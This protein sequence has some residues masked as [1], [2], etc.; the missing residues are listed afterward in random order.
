MYK[1]FSQRKFHLFLITFFTGLFLGLNFSHIAR[2]NSSAQKYLEYFHQVYQLIVSEYVEEPDNKTIFF[3]AIKG[4]ISS[5]GDP[6][7]RVLDEE[8]SSQLQEMTTG[9]FV[10]IGIEIAVRDGEIVVVAPIDN[11]PA[12]KAGIEPGDVITRVNNEI[13][14]DKNLEDVLKNIKGLPGTKVSITI[15]RDGFDEEITYD[16]ERAPIK[17]E[18]TEFAIIDD[19]K[20]G[21][22][23]IKTFGNDTANDVRKA[24]DFFKSKK[25][26]KLIIDLRF[27]PGGLLNAAVDIAD[28]FLDKG[29]VIVSTKGRGSNAQENFFKAVNPQVYSGK[30]VILVNKGS[31][32]ASEILSGALRDNN[33]AILVG[34]KTFGKGSVQKTYSLDKDLSVAITVAKYYTPSGA[35]IHGK[36]IG[37][38]KEVPFIDIPESENEYLKKLSKEKILTDFV[39]VKTQYNEATKVE[40]HKLLSSRNIKLSDRTADLILKR[41]INKYHK[42]LPYD[43]EFDNQLL[44]ALEILK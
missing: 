38:D 9:K 33:R 25:I 20:T 23:Q 29:K 12:M 7:T 43:L 15:R 17:I 2:A 35:M 24:I 30:I 36:G 42:S 22:L 34:E 5:L 39:T 40:F 27:N 32:S 31:A 8:A 3:G 26:D 13:I 21:Y 11:S 28:F 4:M 18:S 44:T 16:I 1:I 14:K 37:P 6:F 19:Y 41:E 10:G